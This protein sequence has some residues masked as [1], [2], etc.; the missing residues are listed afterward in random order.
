MFVFCYHVFVKASL[1]LIFLSFLFF[2]PSALAGGEGQALYMK[3]CSPCHGRGGEGAKGPALRKE[4]LLRTVGKEYFEKS[5]RS[6]RPIL[7]CPSFEGRLTDIEMSAIASHIKSW[8]EGADLE[9]PTHEVKPSYSEG[10][11]RLFSLCGGCHGLEGEGAMGPPL[12]DPGLLASISDTELRRTIMWGRPGTPMKGYLRDM[13][14]LA[15]LS[16]EEIDEILSYMRYRQ[17]AKRA[18]DLPLQ[19]ED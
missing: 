2:V 11:E 6:G 13:G 1:A 15:V 19:Q 9:A 18:W 14:G 10:G 5:M 16:P 12:L 7:G 17:K 8:Q 4:G 3:N